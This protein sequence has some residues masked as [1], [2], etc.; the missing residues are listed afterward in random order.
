MSNELIDNIH[1]INI[2]DIIKNYLQLFKKG[3]NYLAICPFHG[4]TK[5]S[6]TINPQKNI[7]KCFACSTGGDAIKFVMLYKNL[8]YQQALLE[9]AEQFNLDKNLI[10]RYK[11]DNSFANQRIYDLNSNY[12]EFCQSFLNNKE[13]QNA[14]N[15]LKNRGIDEKIINTFKIGFNPDKSGRDLYDLLTNSAG[16][17]INIDDESIYSRDE[18]LDNNLILISNNGNIYDVFRNRLVFSI[19]DDQGRII[20]FSGRVIDSNFEPKYLNTTETKIF[21]KSQILYNWHNAIKDK[22]SIIYLVEGFM[23]VI[24][25]Y[26]VGITNCIATMG[27]AF[28]DE[29]LNKITKNKFI[30]TIV[31]GFDND[32]AGKQAIINVGKKISNKINVYVVKRYD[33]KYKDFDEVLNNSSNE[34]LNEIISN[35]IHFSFFLLEE[36]FQNSFSLNSSSEREEALNSAIGIIHKYGNSL[37]IEEYSK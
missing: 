1:K 2:V 3:N 37:Y 15:Y 8:N 18:L 28:S 19:C 29:H 31:L 35:Q 7:F 22:K 23:D 26:K 11:N 27:T 5:P 32:D 9:I 24:A 21:K 10:T 16:K 30:K 4:D 12:L 33:S 6:L 36:L 25:L 20:G 13:N 34:K 14:L 17:Y